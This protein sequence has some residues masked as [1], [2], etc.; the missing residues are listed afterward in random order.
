MLIDLEQLHAFTRFHFHRYDLPDK[1]TLRDGASRTFLAFQRERILIDP[2]D[3]ITLGDVLGG[4]AHVNA[5]KGV[6]QN[7]QHV[8][9]RL[10]V[11]K[12]ATPSRARQHVGPTTHALGTAGNCNLVFPQQQAL[13]R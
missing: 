6:M 5:V 1:A 4:N 3:T 8:V 2:A 12:T 7:T 11:A 10:H 13:C 9:N